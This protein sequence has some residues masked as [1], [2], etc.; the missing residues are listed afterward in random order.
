MQ[1][2]ERRVVVTGIG[3]V[4]PIGIGTETAWQACIAGKSGIGPITHFDAK[5]YPTRIAGEVTG[6]DPALFMD[7]KEAR[8]ND[9]F[10]QY[11]LAGAQMAL[12]DAGL[13]LD[14]QLGERCG[15]VIGSGM[16]GLTTLEDTHKT[17]VE[18]GLRKVSPFFIPSIIVNLV[19]GQV[20]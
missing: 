20:S 6:F 10:I 12:Q 8:R 1:R 19:G 18:R 13:P 7:K 2:V 14:Q 9:L 3:L 15:V 11:G 4:T 16:G 17:L 5:E